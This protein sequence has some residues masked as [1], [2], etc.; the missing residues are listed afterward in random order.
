M[1]KVCG[2]EHGFR[3]PTKGL[4]LFWS[5][6]CKGSTRTQ[7]S[8]GIAWFH[9]LRAP[10]PQDESGVFPGREMVPT[11]RLTGCDWPGLV[12]DCPAIPQFSHLKGF[13]DTEK[14]LPLLGPGNGPKWVCVEL[15]LH[16]RSCFWF[17][18]VS[19]Q[20]NQQRLPSG[21]PN[22]SRPCCWPVLASMLC[23][24]PTPC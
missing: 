8:Q 2:S 13:E 7:V 4:L 17:P 15:R 10:V 20:S 12:L 19:L 23:P 16:N 18:M 11:E 9:V 1:P 3:R 14:G 24:A 6:H 5:P 21:D 22:S